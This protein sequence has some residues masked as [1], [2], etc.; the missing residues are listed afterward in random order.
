MFHLLEYLDIDYE[1]DVQEINDRWAQASS[2]DVWSQLILK[3]IGDREQQL[4]QAPKTGIWRLHEATGRVSFSRWG[5]DWHS[6]QDESEAFYLRV[7]GPGDYRYRGADLGLLVTRSRMQT[8]A[9]QLTDAAR[10]WIDSFKL[11]FA[12]TPVTPDDAHTGAVAF[13]TA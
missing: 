2:V 12:G 3:E 10:S 13:K 11:E 4:T 1:F 9:N 7:L 8:E 6:L 5:N